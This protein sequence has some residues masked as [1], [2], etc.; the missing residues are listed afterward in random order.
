RNRAGTGERRNKFNL[1]ARARFPF[2]FERGKNSAVHHVAE[3]AKAI[4]DDR[5][6]TRA[7]V[8]RQPRLDRVK[9]QRADDQE[10]GGATENTA[11]MP[12]GCTF[13]PNHA[14]TSITKTSQGS[15]PYEVCSC[16]I[17]QLVWGECSG[18]AHF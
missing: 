16:I 4:D 2:F 13:V 18:K 14:K 6:R 9:H 12:L 17:N 7:R 8:P 15:N 10:N 5:A 1:F 11:P 3:N